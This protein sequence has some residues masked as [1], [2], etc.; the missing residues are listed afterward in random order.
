[1]RWSDGS[2]LEDQNHWWLSGIHR[3]VLLLSKPQVFIADYFFKSSLSKDFSFVEVKIEP[4]S[5]CLLTNFSLEAVIYDTASW[6]EFDGKVDLLASSVAHLNLHHIPNPIRGFHGYILRGKLESPKLWSDEQPNLYTL[7]V[8]LKDASGQQVDCESCQVGFRQIS[9]ATKEILVNG[10]PV[11]IRG[12]NRHEHHPCIVKTNDLILMKQNNVNA[13]RN[14]HYPQHPRWYE[15]CDLFGFYMIDEANIETHGFDYYDHVKHP[16][17]EPSWAYPMLDCV[18]GMVERDKNHACIISWSLGNEAGYGPNHSALD[19][20]IRGRDPTRTVHYEGGGSRTSST[21]I[22]GRMYTLVW[23]IVKLAKDPN[24]TRPIILCEY[25][26]AM[27]NSN[28]NIHEY[29]EAI[30]NTFGLQGGFIWDWVDHV[31]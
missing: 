2:Y 14:S 19:G 8:I 23:D 29:W 21:N 28:G 15:L 22:I 7:V 20:W 10:H 31:G 24:E 13:V 27:G 4:V 12:V 1:M 25:S 17:L 6:Y 11:K 16:T 26:H 18:I 9:K 30:D 5:N 3:D